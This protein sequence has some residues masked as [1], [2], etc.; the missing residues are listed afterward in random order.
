MLQKKE[1]W[2]LFLPKTQQ[3]IPFCL[4]LQNFKASPKCLFSTVWWWTCWTLFPGLSVFA[5]N[6]TLSFTMLSQACLFMRRCLYWVSTPL[7]L[8]IE[9]I[10]G[11]L[12]CT[13][14]TSLIFMRCFF[15]KSFGPMVTFVSSLFCDLPHHPGRCMLLNWMDDKSYQS[16][17]HLQTNLFK[18]N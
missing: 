5:C 8:I 1:A 6:F 18:S 16:P 9:T 17:S 4:C 13:Y 11:F 15:F 7:F 2:C 10:S 3:I 12:Y 14:F